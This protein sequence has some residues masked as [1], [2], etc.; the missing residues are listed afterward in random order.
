[1]L[2]SNSN[3]K[4]NRQL[5]RII[6]K[7]IN[8]KETH[9]GRILYNNI[10]AYNF[11]SNDYLGL[12]K[13]PNL[14]KGSIDWSKKYGTSLSSSR[15]VT[16]NVDFVEQIEEK[17][18]FFYKAEECLIFG[19][20]YQLNITAI[21]SIFSNISRNSHECIILSDKLNHAS[22]NIGCKISGHKTLRYRH[23]DMN[24]LESLLLKYKNIK[25]KL[26]VSESVFSMDGDI[27]D[28]ESIRLLAK[29]FNCYLYLDE[30]H[31]VGVAGRNGFGVSEQ[32]NKKNNREITVGT[33]SKAF[34]AYGSFVCCSS[35]IKKNLVN[36]CSGFIYTTALPPNVL[37]SIFVS[38][39]E[40]PKLSQ[41]RKQLLEN[42]NY[43]R[44]AL[45][46]LGFSTLNSK[47]NIIPV[48]KN[49]KT[50]Y[51]KICKH[52]LKKGFFTSLIRPPTVP[53]KM[54]RIRLSLTSHINKKIIVKFLK[55]L[56][57]FE[58]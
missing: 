46:N 31:A 21:P 30:A 24:H 49:S 52:L 32:L 5:K 11:S 55:V 26:I 58:K 2:T 18:K 38:I 28:I 8:K 25:H 34:G 9:D 17:I 13:N 10:L 54:D 4:K 12:S 7:K 45:I 51:E 48:L 53:F 50:N 41:K 19:S 27:I 36:Y 29:K 20:G 23:L 6:L 47:T 33:F 43:M 15:L 57:D 44:E 37:G 22:I 42:S 35:L 14:I 1:M 39:N 16:G 40:M 3:N 56:K